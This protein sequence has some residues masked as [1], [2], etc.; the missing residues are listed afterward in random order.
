[1]Y[2]NNYYNRLGTVRQCRLGYEA[3]YD[4]LQYVFLVITHKWLQEFDKKRIVATMQIAIDFPKI[5]TK[6]H[7]RQY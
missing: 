5:S 7:C 3:Y 6:R 1:M 4:V 2:N